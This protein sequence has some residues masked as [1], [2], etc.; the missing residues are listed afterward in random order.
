VDLNSD[1]RRNQDVTIAGGYHNRYQRTAFLHD[2]DLASAEVHQAMERQ[3]GAA[4][5]RIGKPPEHRKE[6]PRPPH[7]TFS[8]HRQHQLRACLDQGSYPRS[9]GKETE[10]NDT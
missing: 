4:G 6:A 1:P 5:I 7:V 3:G 9:Q 2:A 10:D 8:T